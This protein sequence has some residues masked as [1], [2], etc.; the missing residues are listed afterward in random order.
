M[1]GST[2]KPIGGFPPWQKSVTLSGHTTIGLGGEAKYFFD[3][4][5]EG[6]IQESLEFAA[7]QAI[8]VFVLGGGSNVIFS[9][10]GFD[11]LVLRPAMLGY[12]FHVSPRTP[13]VL[14]GVK[15]GENWDDFVRMC[16][17]NGYVGL[18]S[19]SGIPGSCGAVAIQNVGAYGAEISDTLESVTVLDRKTFAIRTLQR[20]YLDLGYRTSR[21]KK[22]DRDHFIILNT[23]F[24][25]TANGRPRLNYGEMVQT[26]EA[27]GYNGD[28]I[29]RGKEGARIVREAVLK[30]RK[31]KSMVY[32]R[33]DPDSISAGS[34]FMNPTL[35]KDEFETLR[36][37]MEKERGILEVPSY[38]MGEGGDVKIP[39]AWLVE[40]SGFGKGT[41]RGMAAI[42]SKHTLAL[43]NLGGSTAGLMELAGEIRDGVREQTGIDLKME[44]VLVDPSPR[45]SSIHEE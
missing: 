34:F 6:E 23:V 5:T 37:K 18:E 39:A 35:K 3:A 22:E 7:H 2:E 40:K 44:P 19:L 29:P 28:T 42:S 30:I 16:V 8:P 14:V 36:K 12:S 45:K 24:R 20:E 41:R 38:P 10:Q 21:F 15:A 26:L 9:D 1:K 13:E 32:D 31:A 33:H 11:G 17:A 4:K 27:D 43:V 25:L